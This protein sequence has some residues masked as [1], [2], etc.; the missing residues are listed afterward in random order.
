[1]LYMIGTLQID[2]RPMG[3]GDFSR[4]GSADLAEKPVIGGLAPSEFMGD[5]GEE[6][7]LSGQLVPFRFGGLDE[8]ETIHQMRR[9][10]ARVPVMRGDGERLGT[11]AITRASETHKEL[12]RDGVGYIVAWSLTL[13]RVQDEDSDGAGGSQLISGLLSMFDGL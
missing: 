4:S 5:G 12:G 8:V 7:T 9:E 3:P 10:G 6:L 1:M 2:T 11:H 13:K